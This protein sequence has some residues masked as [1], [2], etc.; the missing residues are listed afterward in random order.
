MT[1][2]PDHDLI[3]A[4]TGLEGGCVACGSTCGVVTAGALGLALNHEASV[5]ESGEP[6]KREIL[7]R[8]RDFAAWFEKNYGSFLCRERT[9][10]DFYSKWG[11]LFYFLT[12]YRMIGCFRHIRGAMRYL[13]QFRHSAYQ[14]A[15]NDDPIPTSDISQSDERYRSR[16]CA[17]DVL[18]GIRENTGIGNLR[19]EGLSFVFDGGVGLSGGLCGALAG[20]VTGLNIIVGL[21]VRE[22]S[23]WK[24]LKS[25]GIGH[26]NLVTDHPFG[27]GDPFLAGK[28]IIREFKNITESF[29]CREITGRKFSG[30]EDFQAYLCASEECRSLQDQMV[31]AASRV[32]RQYQTAE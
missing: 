31:D 9:R 8:V 23:F 28:Q 18:K 17:G 5:E 13:Y 3:K 2:R 24:T 1:G 30:W 25:F 14:A 4:V 15:F 32:I 16:H 27:S 19:L 20:A 7:N 29:E 21:P 26:V 10:A 22:M 11:Q 12:F 6:A